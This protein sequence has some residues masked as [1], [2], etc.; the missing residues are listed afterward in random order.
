MLPS[1]SEL[2]HTKRPGSPLLVSRCP[3]QSNPEKKLLESMR[4]VVSVTLEEAA[5]EL[6]GDAA[7]VRE[8][9]RHPK[10]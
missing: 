8:L 1:L 4:D 5:T 7:R 2:T 3:S 10:S 6:D 9:V